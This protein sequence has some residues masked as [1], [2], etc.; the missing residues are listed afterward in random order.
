MTPMDQERLSGVAPAL[1]AKIGQILD[2]MSS[3]GTPMFVVQGVRSTVYQQSLYAQG[4]TAPGH[5]VTND[6]GVV[7]R[8]PHQAR[9]DGLG[10]AVD[11][12]F[13]PAPSWSSPFDPGWPWH[14]YGAFAVTLGLIWG[15]DW[16]TLK[17]LDHVQDP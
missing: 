11:C 15:G 17:D 8:S 9:Q 2:H 6:D 14:E 16:K 1:V 12:A 5:I 3:L 10:H 4:R 13:D 7:H